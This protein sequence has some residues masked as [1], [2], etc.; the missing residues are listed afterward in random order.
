MFIV[1]KVLRMIYFPS[2]LFGKYLWE[3]LIEFKFLL[4]F[5]LRIP[6]LCLSQ[7]D[8]SNVLSKLG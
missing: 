8:F 3:K 2:N 7:F 1:K 4:F 5:F 6:R